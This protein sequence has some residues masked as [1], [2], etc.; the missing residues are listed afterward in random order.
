MKV[1]RLFMLSVLTLLV[2]TGCCLNEKDES[3]I[4]E[5]EKQHLNIT[6]ADLIASITDNEKYLNPD[7]IYDLETLDESDSISVIITLDAEG[8]FDSY[9]KNPRGYDSVGTY[10]TGNYDYIDDFMCTC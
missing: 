3:V 9:I 5:S 4:T 8:V 7:L 10:A 1:K 6:Q 2:L